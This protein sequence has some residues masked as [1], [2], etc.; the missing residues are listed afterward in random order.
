MAYDFSISEIDIDREL[1]HSKKIILKDSEV[2]LHL[3]SEIEQGE[4]KMNSKNCRIILALD[5]Q[6]IPSILS[7]DSGDFNSYHVLIASVFSLTHNK[8]AMNICGG[9]YLRVENLGGKE[10]ISIEGQSVSFGKMNLSEL[11]KVFSRLGIDVKIETNKGE[12]STKTIYRN[13]SYD[14][15]LYISQNIE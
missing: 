7:S 2:I 10:T 4:H 8:C 11:L 1:K 15:L 6:G 9:G 12:I 13:N 14:Q 3:R 5:E